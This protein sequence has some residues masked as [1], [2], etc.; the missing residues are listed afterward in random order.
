[1]D[2]VSGP[3]LLADD[4]LPWPVEHGTPT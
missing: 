2:Q 4:V 3:Q 1:V